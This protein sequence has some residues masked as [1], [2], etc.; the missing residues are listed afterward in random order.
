[1]QFHKGFHQR[2]EMCHSDGPRGILVEVA[3]LLEYLYKW[4][5]HL[6]PIPTIADNR[7]V[8]LYYSRDSFCSNMCGQMV[9]YHPRNIKTIFAW[10]ASFVETFFSKSVCL[11]SLI[12]VQT[13]GHANGRTRVR[14]SSYVGCLEM[15]FGQ[16]ESSSYQLN[17]YNIFLA[18]LTQP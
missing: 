12:L 17:R 8:K 16:C 4:H 18:N 3:D 2:F 6:Y 5:K 7:V 10:C 15:P 14:L 11:N 9:Q 1:M 13:Y